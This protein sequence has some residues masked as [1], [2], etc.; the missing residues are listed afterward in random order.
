M[1][2]I[3][4]SVVSVVSYPS[5][6]FCSAWYVFVFCFDP[7]PFDSGSAMFQACPRSSKSLATKCH[8]VPDSP[9]PQI[10]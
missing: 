4:F 3:F 9:T 2:L 8:Q 1:A 10:D 5:M 7:F 6:S